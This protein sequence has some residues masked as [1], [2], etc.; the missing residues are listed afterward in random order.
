MNKKILII[1]LIISVAINLAAVGTFCY[2]RW[3][4]HGRFSRM[5]GNMP[6]WIAE[7]FDWNKSYLKNKLDLTEEQIEKLN[8]GQEAMRTKALPYMKE[9]FDMQNEFI[10]MMKDDEPDSVRADSIFK[11]IV[12][13]QI[14]L[15]TQVFKHMQK[16][17]E[18]FTSEQ[19]QIL[20]KLF[21]KH[22]PSP[23]FEPRMLHERRH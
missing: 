12:S 7:G 21:E 4:G 23:P 22:M 14:A 11:E 2:F 10:S 15:E 1:A 5:P 13:V 17:R 3:V 9:L 8:T 20:M 19:R 6:P 18:I 16:M